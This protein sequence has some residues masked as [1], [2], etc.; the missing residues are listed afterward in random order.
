M[1][2][3]D[4]LPVLAEQIHDGKLNSIHFDDLNY[5]Q[6]QISIRYAGT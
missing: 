2:S 1:T 5:F 6:F 4:D 3:N